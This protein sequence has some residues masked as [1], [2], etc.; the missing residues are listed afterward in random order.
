MLQKETGLIS[1][2]ILFCY[3][4]FSYNR[5]FFVC[6]APMYKILQYNEFLLLFQ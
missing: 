6:I 4:Y 5:H 2:I 1:D 3:S